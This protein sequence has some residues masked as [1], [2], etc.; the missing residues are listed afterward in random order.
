VRLSGNYLLLSIYFRAVWR[1]GHARRR[2]AG[3]GEA[4]KECIDCGTAVIKV[5]QWRCIYGRRKR[6][7]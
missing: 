5:P 1:M 2:P 6:M 7:A 3:V 4:G